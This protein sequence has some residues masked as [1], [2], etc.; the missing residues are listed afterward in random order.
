MGFQR[1]KYALSLLVMS[2]ASLYGSYPF[3]Q[4]PPPYNF[5]T[6]AGFRRDQLVFHISNPSPIMSFY[7]KKKQSCNSGCNDTT[8]D[9]YDY[10]DSYNKRNRRKPWE[11]APKRESEEGLPGPFIDSKVKWKGLNMAQV[12]GMVNYSSYNHYYL[13]AS[14][15]Y[16]RIQAGH[17]SVDNTFY[18]QEK[19]SRYNDDYDR[20]CPRSRKVHRNHH[21]KRDCRDR[22]CL[23]KEESEQEARSNSGSVG[24]VSAAVG[25]KAIS[26]SGRTWI[27]GFGGY[28]GSWQSLELRHFTQVKDSLGVFGVGPLCCVSGNYSTSWQGPFVGFDSSTLVDYNVTLFCSGEWHWASYSAKGNWIYTTDYNAR[29]RHDARGYGVVGVL[30]VDWRPCAAW[31]FGVLGNFQQWSTRHGTNRSDLRCST[32]PED[33]QAAAFPVVEK[34]RLQNVKWISFSVSFLA[35]YRF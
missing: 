12:G 29:I 23:R 16:G 14:G 4:E 10:V 27:A 25:W 3:C 9:P 2:G 6:Y 24:D 31:A 26:S 34:C 15:Q 5:H 33:N 17:A 11:C 1:L 7:K 13:R 22:F 30:G 8:G 21:K 20:D 19:R 18:L 35:S 32:V 28:S